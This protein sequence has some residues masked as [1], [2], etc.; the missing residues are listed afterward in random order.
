MVVLYPYKE[1]WYLVWYIHC[2]NLS[3][4]K[5]Q[6]RMVDVS[7]LVWILMCRG[8]HSINSTTFSQALRNLLNSRTE[9][10]LCLNGGVTLT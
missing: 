3:I 9:P 4:A 10:S 1:F 8:F 5:P 7:D 6:Q 2:G